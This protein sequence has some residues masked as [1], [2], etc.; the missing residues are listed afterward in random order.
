MR[1]L[2]ALVLLCVAAPAFA[3]KQDSLPAPS[4]KPILTLVTDHSVQG[5][6]LGAAFRQDPDLVALCQKCTF[7]E[8]SDTN[9]I[10]KEGLARVIPGIPAV[11]LQD[12]SNG[13]V[14]YCATGENIP[15]IEQLDDQITALWDAYLSAQKIAEP[16]MEQTGSPDCP[17]GT[18]PPNWNQIQPQERIVLPLLADTIAK[19]PTPIRDTIS[20]AIWVLVL[21]VVAVFLMLMAFAVLALILVLVINRRTP[22]E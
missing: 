22:P 8:M 14:V 21:A 10:Y 5:S 11:I 4:G 1:T 18:C 6:L 7:H 13:G 12:P 19:R 9:P 15:E 17:D 16:V 20:G 3:Q 2:L